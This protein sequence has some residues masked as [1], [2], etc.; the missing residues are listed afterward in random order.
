MKKIIYKNKNEMSIFIYKKSSQILIKMVKN[1]IVLL[2]L[3][4]T[5]Y[6]RR[7]FF[8][9]KLSSD[10]QRKKSVN[11]KLADIEL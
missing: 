4:K 10:S 2:L 3:A 1:V 11:L 9:F 6:E 7:F 5:K 8:V